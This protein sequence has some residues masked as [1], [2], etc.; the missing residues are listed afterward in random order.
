MGT[1]RQPADGVLVALHDSKRSACWIS[2]IKC[3]QDSINAARRN[4][5][6]PVLVPVVRED[7]SRR[8]RGTDGHAG[9]GGWRMDRDGGGEVVLGRRRSSE[10]EDAEVGVG[11]HG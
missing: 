8:T 1:P 10:V 6:V 3:A 4:H 5:G 2:N 9:L 7:L 11:G